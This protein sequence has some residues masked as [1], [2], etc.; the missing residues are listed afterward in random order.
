MQL[1]PTIRNYFTHKEWLSSTTLKLMRIWKR[2]KLLYIVGRNLVSNIAIK[3]NSIKAAL[4]SKKQ[5]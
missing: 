4:Q 3:E 2:G 5:K 1:K